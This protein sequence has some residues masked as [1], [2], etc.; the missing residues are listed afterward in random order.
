M[1]WSRAVLVLFGL[2]VSALC[3]QAPNNFTISGTVVRLGTNEPLKHAQ[4]LI[5]SVKN[6]EAQVAASTGVDGRFSFPNVPAGKYSLEVQVGANV[7]AF[8]QYEGFSTAIAVGPGVDSEHIVFPVMA[9]LSISGNVLDQE[10]EPVANAQVLLFRQGVFNGRRHFQMQQGATTTAAGAFHIAHLTPGTYFLACQGRPWYAQ[11]ELPSSAAAQTASQA[12]FDV[13]YPLTYYPDALDF[14]AASPIV[15][16]GSS[17]SGIQITLRAVPGVHLRFTGLDPQPGV[18][19][20]PQ[21]SQEGPGD[22]MIATYAGQYSSGNGE[23]GFFGLAPGR[24]V[25]AVTRWGNSNPPGPPAGLGRKTLDVS[26][27]TTVDLGSLHQT[28]ISGRVAL[29]TAVEHPERL[30][31]LLRNVANEQAEFG[32]LQADGSFTVGNVSPGRY[33][34]QLVNSPDL[35]IQRVSVKGAPYSGGV[36]EIAEGAAVELSISAGKGLA[37]A[38]VGGIA[39]KDEQPFAGAMVL[40]LPKDPNSTYIGRDQSDGDGTFTLNP[41]TPP[42]RYTLIA[43]DDGRD[44]AYRDPAVMAPYLAQ[45][46]TLEVPLQTGAPVQ[47]NVIHRQRQ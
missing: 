17:V 31:I 6:R 36:L 22:T 44:L 21:L 19:I 14:S 41:P 33:E 11:N 47:V 30:M 23:Q 24:Y 37:R 5:A 4:V 10:G 18:P 3:R 34:I 28:T 46:Q 35:Y 27:D 32:N 29:E 13:A 45:G 1:F 40:L 8:H 20:Q 38:S 9:S 15:L 42:G 2:V 7:E 43:I 25:I 12:Q 26:G 16:S 39:L